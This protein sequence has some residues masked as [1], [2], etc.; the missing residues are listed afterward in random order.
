MLRGGGRRGACRDRLDAG[1][2]RPHGCVPD[3]RRT[4][5]T[6][7]ALARSDVTEPEIV[8]ALRRARVSGGRRQRIA[9]ARAF[10]SGARLVILDEP[11]A[12]LDPATAREL[13]TGV[14]GDTSG[15]GILLVTRTPPPPGTAGQILHLESGRLREPGAP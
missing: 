7:V 2:G 13:L 4:A 1:D 10:P 6:G 15:A 5:R 11:T 8:D 9:P 12:H 3:G 14:L